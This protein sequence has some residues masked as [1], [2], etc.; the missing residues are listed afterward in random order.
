M[1]TKEYWNQCSCG[2]HLLEGDDLIDTVYP[3][4]REKTVYNAYCNVSMGGC[5]RVV[6]ADSIA[7]LMARWNAGATDE[8]SESDMTYCL[9]CISEHIKTMKYNKSKNSALLYSLPLW[10]NFNSDGQQKCKHA[11]S[12]VK[13]MEDA[14]LYNC[15]QLLKSSQ[16]SNESFQQE[17]LGHLKIDDLGQ[18]IKIY[19]DGTYLVQF[20]DDG[21]EASNVYTKDDLLLL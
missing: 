3:C 5:G 17:G 4:N 15:V 9:A 12:F 7:L 20:I 14:K 18:I 2:K 16:Y 8:N 21:I 11:V 10:G 19:D 1:S 13:S 6:Y